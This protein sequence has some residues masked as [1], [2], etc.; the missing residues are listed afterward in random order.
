MKP[1]LTPALAA[2]SVVQLQVCQALLHEPDRCWT[3]ADMGHRL[4][5]VAV[6]DLR[7]ILH[8]LLGDRLMDIEQAAQQRCLALRLN[9]DGERI[10][11]DALRCPPQIPRDQR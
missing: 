10:L 1:L 5:G 7:I 3:V 9:E 6:N 8:L 11:A 4:Q 2:K